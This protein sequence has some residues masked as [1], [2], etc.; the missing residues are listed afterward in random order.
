MILSSFSRFGLATIAGAVLLTGCASSGAV[1][2]QAQDDIRQPGDDVPAPG[3]AAK[4][5]MSPDAKDQNLI[6]V[7]DSSTY[8]VYAYSFPDG[9]LVG[10]LTNQNNPAGLCT[11]GVGDVF[12]TQLYGHQILEYAHGGT[13]PIETLSDPGYEPGACSIDPKTGNLAVANVVSDR[14]TQ[15]NLLVYPNA[16]GT[17]TLYS[18]PGGSSGSWLSVNGVGYD[19]ASNAYFAGSCNSAFCAGVLPAGS[20]NTENITL[21]MSPKSPGTVQWDGFD[22]TF[23]DQS[24]GTV[25]SYRFSGTTGTKYRSQRL[26]RSSDVDGSWIF[27]YQLPHKN[28]GRYLVLAPQQYRGGVFLYHYGAGPHEKAK[29]LAN[30]VAQPFGST[31]SGRGN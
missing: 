29:R 11:D 2:R 3:G 31:F 15:G 30:R 5:W 18:L 13:T 7:S 10:T 28:F 23:D 8:G 19:N 25:Y 6:Y 14:L 20:G 16:S 1:L 26:S 9:R 12:V 27:V 17:P 4:S 21:N 24:D 22:M